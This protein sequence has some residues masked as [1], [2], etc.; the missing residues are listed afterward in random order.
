MNNYKIKV[1]GKFGILNIICIIILLITLIFLLCISYLHSQNDGIKEIVTNWKEPQNTWNAFDIVIFPIITF[2]L[3][4]PSFLLF[5]ILYEKNSFWCEVSFIYFLFV[6][7]YNYIFY[8]FILFL[9]IFLW[10]ANKLYIDLF[11]CL[12]SC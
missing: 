1:D 3:F 7:E 5:S 10:K 11:Y 4:I 9:K 2:H 6:Y 8:I 12:V